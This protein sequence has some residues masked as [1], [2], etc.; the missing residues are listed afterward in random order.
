MKKN[1]NSQ[2]QTKFTGSY[3]KKSVLSEKHLVNIFLNNCTMFR[4]DRKMNKEG[5]VLYLKENI[6]PKLTSIRNSFS[7]FMK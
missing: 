4:K 6:P 3:I 5:L 2:P 1:K 7:A